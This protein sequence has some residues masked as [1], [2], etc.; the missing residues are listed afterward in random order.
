M[1]VFVVCCSMRNCI[2][3]DFNDSCSLDLS[4]AVVSGFFESWGRIGDSGGFNNRN[5]RGESL[6]SGEIVRFNGDML[7]L[8]NN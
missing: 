1:P 7:R 5:R 8:G 2:L 3:F 6:F 4:F